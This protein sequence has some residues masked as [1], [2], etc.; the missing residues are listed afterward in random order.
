MDEI[1]RYYDGTHISLYIRK[2]KGSLALNGVFEDGCL[3]RIFELKDI[4]KLNMV[5]LFNAALLVR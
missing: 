5:S 1:C 3:A 4:K 2:S